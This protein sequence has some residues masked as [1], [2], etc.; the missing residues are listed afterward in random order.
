MIIGQNAKSL[1]EA[2]KNKRNTTMQFSACSNMKKEY[3]YTTFYECTIEVPLYFTLFPKHMENDIPLFQ[4][5]VKLMIH[6]KVILQPYP[7]KSIMR[8]RLK[9]NLKFKIQ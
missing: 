1:I 7:I 5:E 3:R 4:N 6:L 8:P 2:C 9:N